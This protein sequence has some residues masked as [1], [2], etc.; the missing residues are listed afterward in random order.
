MRADDEPTRSRRAARPGRRR[1]RTGR[2]QRRA[3]ERW[4]ALRR[5]ALLL[6][7]TAV[8]GVMQSAMLL[9]PGNGKRWFARVYWAMLLPADGHRAPGDRHGRAQRARAPGAVRLQPHLLA[10]RARAGRDARSLLRRQGRGRAV[11]GDPH[12]RAA[13]AGPCSSA[14][15]R[16]RPGASGTPCATRLAAGDG[17]ILFPEGTSSDGARVLPFRSPFFSVAEA[18]EGVGRLGSSRSRSSTTAST[19]CRLAGRPGRSRPGTATWSWAAISGSLA[20]HRTLR[21]TILLHD[22]DRPGRV[23][24][25]ARRCR[26]RYGASSPRARPCCGRTGLRSRSRR[27]CRTGQHRFHLTWRRP[28]LPRLAPVDRIGRLRSL[29]RLTGALRR[30]HPPLANGARDGTPCEWDDEAAAR[31]HLGLPDERLRQRPHGGRAGAARLRADRR[32]PTTRTW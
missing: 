21:A 2:Q 20:R 5:A 6:L 16:A 9:L 3:A 22:P 28:V 30:P 27:P 10:R 15:E 25:R 32:R 1:A 7:W 14:A 13:W 11:A 26:P 18:R 8:S 31:D 29:H 12:D 4:R 23:S 17:L 24:R 19:G